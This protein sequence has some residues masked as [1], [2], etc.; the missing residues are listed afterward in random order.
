MSDDNKDYITLL[1][2]VPAKGMV[3]AKVI[4]AV[5]QWSYGQDS[6]YPGPCSHPMSERRARA[7][8]EQ[9][10]KDRGLEIR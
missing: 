6:Y 1:P 9:M 7:L 5:M 8:Q 3:V 2:C 4:V 10:A